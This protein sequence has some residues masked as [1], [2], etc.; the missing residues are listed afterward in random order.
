VWGDAVCVDCSRA[1]RKNYCRP[2]GTALTDWIE[3]DGETV[4]I[5]EGRERIRITP[6]KDK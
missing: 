1:E 2:D 6:R 3:K 4:F 5:D